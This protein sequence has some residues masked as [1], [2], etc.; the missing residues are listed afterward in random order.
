MDWAFVEDI[1]RAGYEHKTA[2]GYVGLHMEP[3]EDDWIGRN[4]YLARNYVKHRHTTADSFKKYMETWSQVERTNI[5]FRRY[6][7]GRKP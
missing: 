2:S 3:N 6:A 5:E 4:R 1:G 7:F